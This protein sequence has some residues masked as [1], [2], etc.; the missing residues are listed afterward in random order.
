MAGT[1]N[2]A[3]RNVQLLDTVTLRDGR[4]GQVR[5]RTLLKL[6]CFDVML[7]DGS[8]DIKV[9]VPL[10]DIEKINEGEAT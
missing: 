2:S 9:N 5:A 6:W 4:T 7:I 10:S 1:V 3:E 8:R